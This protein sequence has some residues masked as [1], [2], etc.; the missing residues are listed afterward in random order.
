MAATFFLVRH[1]SFDG[2]GERLAG[3]AEGFCLNSKGKEEAVALARRLAGVHFSAIHSSPRTRA[4]ETAQAIATMADLPVQIDAELDEIDYGE[5]TGKA[6]RDLDGN[7][8]WHRFNALRSLSRIPSGENMMEVTQRAITELDRCR[9]KYQGKAVVLIT[10]ADWIRAALA[11]CSGIS[12]DHMLR[13][14]ISPASVSILR[15]N[16]GRPQIIR[17][18]D[19]GELKAAERFGE[20]PNGTSLK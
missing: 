2:V 12:L 9:E 5:W 18:N 7:P 17:L 3:R 20:G 8:E 10:H 4:R 16:D 14:E 1:A 11:Y 19:T 6:F 15:L 13:L